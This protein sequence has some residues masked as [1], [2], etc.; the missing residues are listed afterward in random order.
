MPEPT[1]RQINEVILKAGVVALVDLKGDR[2]WFY[3][4]GRMP[5]HVLAYIEIN[6]RSARLRDFLV[7]VGRGV[8]TD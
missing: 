7:N 3:P 1:G 5:L 6:H 8:V 4:R 2:I